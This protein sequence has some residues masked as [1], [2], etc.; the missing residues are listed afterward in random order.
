MSSEI[1]DA[2]SFV[3]AW[4]VWR[5]IR[6]GQHKTLEA[7]TAVLEAVGCCISVWG[8]EILSKITFA[9]S[10]QTLELVVVT[11]GEL[12]GDRNAT[13][14]EIFAAGLERGLHKC[15][16]EVGPALREQYKD[17]P[18]GEW[19]LVAME[20]IE[21]SVRDLRVFVVGHVVGGRWLGANRGLPDSLFDPS[22]R[23]V[24]LAPK[25]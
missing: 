6:I 13:V 12:C 11:G 22:G 23:W 16:A 15:P 24:F 3:P 25:K 18:M 19:L 2:A 20:P 5:T 8:H 21:D 4:P 9:Q 10:A 14:S 17:Q 7:W 1:A